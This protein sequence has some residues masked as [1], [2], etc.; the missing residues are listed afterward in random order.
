MIEFENV[1]KNFDINGQEQVI[2]DGIDLKIDE[3]DIFGLVG[4]T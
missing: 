2:I 3:K 1:S 4:E